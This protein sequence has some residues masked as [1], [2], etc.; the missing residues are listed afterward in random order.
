MNVSVVWGL[1]YVCLCVVIY[2]DDMVV[3]WGLVFCL[4]LEI[5]LS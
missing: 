3:V 5:V 1:V 2:V 4:C